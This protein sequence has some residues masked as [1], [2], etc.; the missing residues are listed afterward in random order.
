MLISKFIMK[1]L[2]KFYKRYSRRVQA[3]RA[4]DEVFQA[5]LFLR[6]V[7]I[8]FPWRRI[9]RCEL[10]HIVS[11]THPDPTLVRGQI[12]E[13]SVLTSPFYTEHF[14]TSDFKYRIMCGQT[15]TK[16]DEY[17]RCDVK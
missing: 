2:C 1:D 4:P 16:T 14:V 11:H 7:E 8:L 9:A 12:V 15:L 13:V 10:L 6:M 5:S 17:K 3:E